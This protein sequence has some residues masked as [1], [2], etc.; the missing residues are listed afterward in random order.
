MDLNDR[1]RTEEREIETFR[2]Q[3]KYTEVQNYR[4]QGYTINF[5]GISLEIEWD[6]EPRGWR[7]EGGQ[8]NV[9]RSIFRPVY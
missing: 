9:D 8:K 5:E 1:D 4:C 2:K 3:D 7:V 6:Y